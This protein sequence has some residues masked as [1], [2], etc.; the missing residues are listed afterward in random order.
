MPKFTIDHDSAQNP[1]EVFVKIK[2]FL[3]KD[4]DIRRFDPK[5]QCSFDPQN[6]SASLKGSQFKADLQIISQ[7]AGSKVTVLVD[8]PL[9]LTP[10]KGKI[11]DTLKH[12]LN[13]YLG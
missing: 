8:L 9:L 13:K 10:F 11:Q 3:E 7:N 5:L 12:K 6:K 4:Q 1:E 2:E